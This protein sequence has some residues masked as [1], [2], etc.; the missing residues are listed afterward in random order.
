MSSRLEALTKQAIQ[1]HKSGKTTE[2]LGL[3]RRALAK[4]PKNPDL[5]LFAS[6]AAL[7][8]GQPA[9]AVGWLKR[10]VAMRPDEISLH[11]NLGKSLKQNGQYREAIKVFEQVLRS[12]PNNGQALYSLASLRNQQGETERAIE[13]LYQALQSDRP[14]V[15]AHVV[16]SGM[17]IKRGDLVAA[18]SV[19]EEALARKPNHSDCLYH[20]GLA[21]RRSGDLAAAADAYR[22]AFDA[23]PKNE[24]ALASVLEVGRDLCQWEDREVLETNLDRLTDQDVTQGR[25]PVEAPFAHLYRSDDAGRNFALA[26]SWSDAITLIADGR[27]GNDVRPPKQSLPAKPADKRRIGYFCAQFY[28]HPVMRCASAFMAHHD[29]EA[30]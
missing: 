14:G 4:S 16:L 26:R 2:A 11:L 13:L 8:A 17:L 27:A 15:R 18:K 25:Q 19:L 9:L 21:L 28:D 24:P 22:K 29:H 30:F 10:A 3:Y 20:L 5:L 6:S 7:S 12:Q 1:A 23:N